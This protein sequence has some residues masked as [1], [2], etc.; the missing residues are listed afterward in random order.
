MF[1]RIGSEAIG[2]FFWIGVG[3]SFAI[4]GISLN[5]GILKN[6]GPGFLPVMMATLLVL[7]SLFILIKGVM[8]PKVA[9]PKIFWKKQFLAV[10][11]VFFYIFLLEFIDFLLSTFILMFILFTILIK[12]KN[13]WPKILC[14]SAAVALAAW[15]VFYVV[16]RTPFPFP[17]FISIWS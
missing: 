8:K 14:Y 11:S 9:F 6:P 2:S 10:V 16:I 15:L 3:I 1:R 13:K 12:E 17:R 7:F 5:V 4:E